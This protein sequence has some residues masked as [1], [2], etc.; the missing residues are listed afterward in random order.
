M[1]DSAIEDRFYFVPAMRLVYNR[2]NLESLI[3]HGI[4]HR[5]SV[6]TITGAIGLLFT[7]KPQ[8]FTGKEIFFR[9]PK[10]LVTQ[11]LPLGCL[12]VYWRC[13]HSYVSKVTTFNINVV[14]LEQQN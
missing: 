4:T 10:N 2:A 1:H 7:F 9:R 3:A 8:L 11:Q 5:E 6:C 13:V 12:G 14:L